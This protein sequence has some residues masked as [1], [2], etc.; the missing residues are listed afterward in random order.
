MES[1]NTIRTSDPE[2]NINNASI[3][4]RVNPTKGIP[5]SLY[6]MSLNMTCSQQYATSLS[7]LKQLL[8][9]KSDF[10]EVKQGVKGQRRNIRFADYF[11]QN[12]TG[13]PRQLKRYL[14]RV[15][16]YSAL[17]TSDDETRADVV[18]DGIALNGAC[19]LELEQ[20]ARVPLPG[21][22]KYGEDIFSQK[23]RLL[24]IL[25]T[26]VILFYQEEQTLALTDLKL[27]GLMFTG[28][29]QLFHQINTGSAT[30]P[31]KLIEE[32]LTRAITRAENGEGITLL[33]AF[34]SQLRFMKCLDPSW[35]NDDASHRLLLFN[36]CDTLTTEDN[37]ISLLPAPS[38][39]TSF[40]GGGKRHET[41]YAAQQVTDNPQH[42]WESEDGLEEEYTIL[43]MTSKQSSREEGVDRKMREEKSEREDSFSK[44]FCEPPCACCGIKNHPMLSPIRTPDG[45]S[46]NCDYVCPAALYENWQE[47]RAKRN[48]NRTR[49]CP[50]KFAAMCKH[51]AQR[52]HDA[53]LD[54]ERI[55]SGQYS[56]PQ[57]K[58]KF[59]TDVLS[60]CDTPTYHSATP[61]MIQEASFTDGIEVEECNSSSV[62]GLIG[63]INMNEGP[64]H[65]GSLNVSNNTERAIVTSLHASGTTTTSP[66]HVSYSDLLLILA[67]HVEPASPEEIE[68]VRRGDETQM[69]RLE[70]G[71]RTLIRKGRRGGRIRYRMTDGA[72]YVVPYPE[73]S[74]RILADTGSTT[75]LINKDFARMKGLHIS[76]IGRKVLLRDVNNGERVLVDRCYLRLTLT[77]VLCEKM[78]LVI[79]AHCAE[80]LSHDLLLGTNDLEK[81]RISVVSHMGE[82]HMQ[83]GDTIKVLPMLHGTQISHL[84]YCLAKVRNAS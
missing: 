24:D 84:Q 4:L 8:N 10:V 79:L 20:A 14:Q 32:Y 49:P 56:K 27:N 59:R 23:Q 72:E 43:A 7:T 82:A 55:G 38:L 83:M 15:L 37:E 31:A 77:T 75:T 19:S 33:K 81:Y 9:K 67:T 5:D 78:T 71:E 26:F 47:Q 66:Q 70:E 17:L 57:D 42:S 48:L 22:S 60:V 46:L 2:V 40:N 53:L 41:N 80:G 29:T 63:E 11:T 25:L 45:A 62:W 65:E 21:F 50:M 39:Q 1:K 74:G 52:A 69:I 35:N 68:A 3:I 6:N 28:L 61:L 54:Y 13:S 64:L 73:I 18:A 30:L 12:Y 51:E 16:Q 44:R 34:Q 76:N 58:M 36:C